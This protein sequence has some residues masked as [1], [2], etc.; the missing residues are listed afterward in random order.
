[1]SSFGK[2]DLLISA[3]GEQNWIMCMLADCVQLLNSIPEEETWD[4]KIN[5]SKNFRI[6]KFLGTFIRKPVK[7]KD[8]FLAKFSQLVE[9]K[10]VTVH[11]NFD[12]K[13]LDR[14]IQL[15]S[16][17]SN[18]DFLKRFNLERADV[19]LIVSR[20]RNCQNEYTKDR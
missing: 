6:M 4:E 18:E 5:E 11:C 3:S 10:N 7:Y 9:T 15:S 2:R 1:M 17:P 8:Q 12:E 20:V 16:K 13:D 14:L 19:K